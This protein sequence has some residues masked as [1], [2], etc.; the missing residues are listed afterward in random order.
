MTATGPSGEIHQVSPV[1][2][3]LLTVGSTAAPL[4]HTLPQLRPGAVVFVCSEQTQETVVKVKHALAEQL[5]G[6]EP[7]RYKTLIVADPVNLVEC[8]R[9]VAEGLRFLRDE[10]GLEREAIRIDFTGGTKA[11]S[12][13][14]V[15]AAAP[16]GYRFLY[17][18]GAERN[19]GGVGVVQDGTEQLCLP[20]NPWSVLEEPELRRLLEMAAL[21][22]WAAAQ[23]SAR[24]L[25]KR[26]GSD[27]QPVF[28]QLERVLKGLSWWDCFE[29]ERAWKAWEE[30]KA[31]SNLV[32]LAT[33]GNRPLVVAFGRK[34]Q[35]MIS[36]LAP[37][38][39]AHEV[40]DTAETPKKPN[41]KCDLLVLDMLGNGDRRAGRGHY[42]EAALRYYR[43]VE[44]CVSRRLQ[45][46]YGIDNSSVDETDVP[47]PLRE[48]LLRRNGPPD[49]VWK[50]GQRNSIALLAAKDDP[51]GK[52]LLDYDKN[53]NLDAQARNENWLIHGTEHVDE[54][55]CRAYR[56]K[57]L[58]A[59]GLEE[60]NVPRWP[61]FRP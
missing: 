20:E 32:A 12:A 53:K 2:G 14:A 35:G 24:R 38:A 43:A 10:I 33:A 29:H 16:E 11:M 59:L 41:D 42:D 27:G 18:S 45:H 57:T 31:P 44:L 55:R 5:S 50:L 25:L 36:L 21:G 23:D 61:D 19:K 9:G 47:S 17:V 8:H 30:G 7:P 54:K 3:V 28:Q 51:L 58:E 37:V 34:C 15:L 26:A 49:P 4:L 1:K 48:E 40:T 13:A 39:K 6:E 22:Q 60:Q 52:R 56:R 46:L